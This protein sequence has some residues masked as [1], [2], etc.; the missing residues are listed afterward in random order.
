MPAY[1]NDG[2]TIVAMAPSRAERMLWT[3]D[4]ATGKATAY[5]AP[6]EWHLKTVRSFGKQ[7]WV[8]WVCDHKDLAVSEVRGHKNVYDQGTG[9]YGYWEYSCQRFDP[10]NGVFLDGPSELE[11]EDWLSKA[12]PA[13]YEGHKCL[14]IPSEGNRKGESSYDILSLPDLKKQKS[15]SLPQVLPAGDYWWATIS[16]DANEASG[17]NAVNLFNAQGAKVLSVPDDEARRLKDMRGGWPQYARLS[18]D[19]KVLLL[20][21]A[22]QN[23][24]FSYGVFDTTGGKFLWGGV[25]NAL[26]NGNP[27]VKPSEVWTLLRAD[28]GIELARLTPGLK[29]GEDKHV[30]VLTYR[31][32]ADLDNC[33]FNPS[34][35]GSHFVVVLNGKP[36]QLL[37]FPIKDGVTEQDVKVVDLK[38]RR[39]R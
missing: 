30:T 28:T 8:E 18:G 4:L 22:D 27:L 31:T 15:I 12:I 37:F 34:P 39:V 35:D 21:L 29:P 38:D 24:V 14:F 36:P 2:K 6:D 13:S 7:M 16:F 26:L 20:A 33:Q 5:P 17:L 1:T 10:A 19:G 23:A 11:D 32:G 3:Y 9:K 25:H